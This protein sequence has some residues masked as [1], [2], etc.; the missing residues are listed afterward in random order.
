M[1]PSSMKAEPR[2]VPSVIPTA[3]A[4]PRD[5]GRRARDRA[6][7]LGSASGRR[8]REA[9]TA[10][11]LYR[12][13]GDVYSGGGHVRPADVER[14]DD[15]VRAHRTNEIVGDRKSTRLNY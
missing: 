12:A 4:R 5:R 7:Q 13:R 9:D 14:T 10:P 6:Q 11:R 8:K 1:W 15:L 2:P 3:R